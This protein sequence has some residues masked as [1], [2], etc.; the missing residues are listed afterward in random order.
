MIEIAA[1]LSAVVKHWADLIIISFLL[2]LNGVV[3]FWQ[4]FQ[5]ENAI[6]HFKKGLALKARVL[7]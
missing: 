1:L 7:C 4:E 6:E 2:M 5:A 3:G